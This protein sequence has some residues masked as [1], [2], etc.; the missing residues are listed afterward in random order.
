MEKPKLED[1]QDA[2]QKKIKDFSKANRL[3]SDQM[4]AAYELALGVNEP[5]EEMRARIPASVKELAN[6]IAGEMANGLALNRIAALV[7]SKREHEGAYDKY[8]SV[9]TTLNISEK[10]K[11]ILRSI[12]EKKRSGILTISESA[13]GKDI[14]WITL[15][16]EVSNTDFPVNDLASILLQKLPE[17]QGK[18]ISISFSE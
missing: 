4:F 1:P 11:Q 5:N 6:L 9:V 10:E 13:S 7:G 2:Q 8:L 15:P 3:T 16:E 12:V 18:K 14:A 17:F